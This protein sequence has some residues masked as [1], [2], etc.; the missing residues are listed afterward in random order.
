ML[1]D[2]QEVVRNNTETLDPVSPS[3]NSSGCHDKI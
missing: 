1:I 2:S 3:V